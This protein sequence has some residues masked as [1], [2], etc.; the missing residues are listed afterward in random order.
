[1]GE[2]IEFGGYH[3]GNGAPCHCCSYDFRVLRARQEAKHSQKDAQHWEQRPGAC[4]SWTTIGNP[5][6]HSLKKCR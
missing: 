1:M 3:Q 5:H 6:K 4:I 2:V